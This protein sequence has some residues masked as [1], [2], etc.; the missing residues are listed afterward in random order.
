M[1]R[2]Q[3]ELQPTKASGG[4]LDPRQ[5]RRLALVAV[6]V[7]WVGWR[8]WEVWRASQAPKGAPPIASSPALPTGDAAEREATLAV[9]G[10]RSPCRYS[11]SRW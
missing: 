6:L 1:V 9:D 8:A 4:G 10:R 3:A 11:R 2:P 7:L 5:I